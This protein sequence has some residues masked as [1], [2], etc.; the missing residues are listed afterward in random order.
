M[1]QPTAWGRTSS[2]DSSRRLRVASFLGL[3]VFFPQYPNNQQNWNK[4]QADIW[5]FGPRNEHGFFWL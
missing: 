5:N 4:H 2:A 1:F 3:T